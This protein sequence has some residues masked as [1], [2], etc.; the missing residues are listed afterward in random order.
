MAKPV[1]SREE[2]EKSDRKLK[3]LYVGKVKDLMPVLDA[4]IEAQLAIEEADR[5][6]EEELEKLRKR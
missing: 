6:L 3:I 1:Y 5:V 4:A 2:Y